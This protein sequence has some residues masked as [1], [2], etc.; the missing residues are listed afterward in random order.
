MAYCIEGKKV[1]W[2]NRE[3]GADLPRVF[4]SIAKA[5]L[6]GAKFVATWNPLDLISVGKH[7]ADGGT[8]FHIKDN[9]EHATWLLVSRS[10]FRAIKALIEENEIC[11]TLPQ[12]CIKGKSQHIASSLDDVKIF[13]SN[14]SLQYPDTFSFLVDFKTAMAD[15]LEDLGN[16]EDAET[17]A[18]G[19]YDQFSREFDNELRE[20]RANYHCI[21]HLLQDTPATDYRNQVE[22]WIQYNKFLQEQANARIFESNIRLKQVYIGLRAHRSPARD[23]KSCG[24]ATQSRV[25]VDLHSELE[26]WVDDARPDD[27][28]RYVSGG[29]GA[30]KSSFAKVFA[31]DISRSLK[32]RVLFVPI[33]KIDLA[34]TEKLAES[35]TTFAKEI[36][37]LPLDPLQHAKGPGRLLLVLDGLDELSDAAGRLRDDLAGVL[38]EQAGDLVSPQ[39]YKDIADILVLITGREFF[40]QREAR[41]YRQQRCTYQLIGYHLT[42]E[43]KDTYGFYDPNGLLKTDQRTE[44]WKRYGEAI[45][46]DYPEVP[47]VMTN[48]T[49]QNLTAQPLLNYLIA[50]MHTHDSTTFSAERNRNAV[51]RDI[52]TYVFRRDWGDKQHASMHKEHENCFVRVLQAVAVAVWHGP[53]LTTTICEVQKH[54]TQ[55]DLNAWQKLGQEPHAGISRMLTNFFFRYTG[56]ADESQRP[57]EFTHRSFGEYLT[58]RRI[59]DE[60]ARLAEYAENESNSDEIPRFWIRLCGKRALD[61][62]LVSFIRD[63]IALRNTEREGIADTW[64]LALTRVI[65][66]VLRNGIPLSCLEQ[67][68]NSLD[69]GTQT[70]KAEQAL[71]VVLNGCALTTGRLSEIDWPSSTA[72]SDWLYRIR[73]PRTSLPVYSA[74]MDSLGFLKLNDQLPLQRYLVTIPNFSHALFSV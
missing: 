10:L 30:G 55:D 66:R 33:R 41:D 51:Y 6:D 23:E 40:L 17:I 31:A 43:E 68:K 2:L 57:V 13:L 8:A 62:D 36:V 49:M 21:M 32:V 60:T 11:C 37:E 1:G 34:K 22:A 45:A 18:G 54:C 19:L 28:I 15:W 29:P 63:E 61:K 39:K 24:M 47:D 53:G 26:K 58:A 4:A 12:K 16:Y 71:L 44:W 73:G 20:H 56:S 70:R 52:V 25:V 72:F 48:G 67:P 27:A 64:Q 5:G 59:V 7:V 46:T 69:V 65:E 35:L 74:A 14:D 9:P 38:L 50:V 42:E 3:I